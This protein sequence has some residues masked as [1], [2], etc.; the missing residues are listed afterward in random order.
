MSLIDVIYNQKRHNFVEK[1]KECNHLGL[2]SDSSDRKDNS[3]V[4]NDGSGSI[5]LGDDS[6]EFVDDRCW[7]CLWLN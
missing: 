3:W 5:N 2:Q 6:S 1:I 7:N 4:E